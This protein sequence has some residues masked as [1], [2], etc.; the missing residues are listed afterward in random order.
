MRLKINIILSMSNLRGLSEIC[1]MTSVRVGVMG[2]GRSGHCKLR[3]HLIFAS[4]FLV[5]R[6]KY[7]KKLPRTLIFLSV[8]L[9]TGFV[10]CH[11]ALHR[12]CNVVK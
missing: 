9:V 12:F 7:L 6:I 4:S 3:K 2:L 10:K 11:M 8:L 5:N 1:A